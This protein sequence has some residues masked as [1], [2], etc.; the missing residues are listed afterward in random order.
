LPQKKVSGEMPPRVP[1]EPL[2]QTCDWQVEPEL[3]A[4]PLGERAVQVIVVVSHVDVFRHA[5]WAPAHDVPSAIRWVHWE[6]V[7]PTKEQYAVA[8]QSRSSLHAPPTF[9]TGAQLFVIVSQNTPLV[10]SQR[11][12]WVGA[13]LVPELIWVDEKLAL[14]LTVPMHGIAPGLPVV[15]V[16][17]HV[18]TKPPSS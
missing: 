13:T 7:A 14:W 5:D 15:V 8:T 12:P 4:A 2:A 1:Q 16:C 3:Q 6:P 18:C 17:T 10:L 9:C 11:K